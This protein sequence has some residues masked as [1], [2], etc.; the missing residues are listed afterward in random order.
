MMHKFALKIDTWGLLSVEQ[1]RKSIRNERWCVQLPRTIDS[2]CGCQAIEHH[3][4]EAPKST[5]SVIETGVDVNP[6][7]NAQRNEVLSFIQS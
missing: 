6:L 4:S 5:L 1:T 2:T 3:L 7:N